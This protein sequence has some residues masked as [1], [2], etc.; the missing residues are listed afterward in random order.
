MC[1]I[2]QDIQTKL[3][4]LKVLLINSKKHF[5]I[6]SHRYCFSGVSTGEDCGGY[7]CGKETYYN[8]ILSIKDKTATG[9]KK[10]KQPQEEFQTQ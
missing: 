10:N 4:N 5:T 3:E 8:K 9:G 1:T 2:V 6:K 7:E